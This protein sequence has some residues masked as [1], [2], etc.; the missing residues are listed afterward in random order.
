VHIVS[1][2]GNPVAAATTRE[3]ADSYIEEN[4][5]T[6]TDANSPYWTVLF[7]PVV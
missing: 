1:Y 4:R 3:A 2:F 5:R 6:G 7:V